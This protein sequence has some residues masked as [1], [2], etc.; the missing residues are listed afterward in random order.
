MARTHAHRKGKSHSIRPVKPDLSFVT[1]DKDQ[2]IDLIVKFGKE[3]LSSSEI[4]I[5]LRDEY[6]I[7]LVKPI[8]GKSINEILEENGIKGELPEDLSNLLKKALRLQQHLREHPTDRNN[9]RSLELIEAKI[10]RLSKY[11]KQKGLLPT[12]WKYTAAIAQLE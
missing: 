10:H 2:I 7:P 12:K 3:G 5:K 1:M 4:G 11:Y 9:I 8:V 6:G